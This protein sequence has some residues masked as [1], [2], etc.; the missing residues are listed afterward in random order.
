VIKALSTSI[1]FLAAFTITTP[2]A[3]AMKKHPLDYVGFDSGVE[4][5]GSAHLFQTPSANMTCT[6]N[7]Q[8]VDFKNKKTIDTLRCE[9]N[10]PQYVGYDLVPT[11]IPKV[12]DDPG[13]VGMP[14][15][16]DP[17]LPYGTWW[18]NG[19]IACLSEE[20]G[21]T[22]KNKDGHGFFL[23]KTQAKTF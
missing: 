23:S 13:D 15:M 16:T 8:Y 5:P 7:R 2:T 19:S 10:A 6:L 17:T 22:C 21:L 12:V 20:K 4:V 14:W 1:L 9:R 11:G 3:F 18:S